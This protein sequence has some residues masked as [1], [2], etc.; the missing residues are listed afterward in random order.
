MILQKILLLM[1]KRVI[2]LKEFKGLKEFKS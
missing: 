2:R 1:V